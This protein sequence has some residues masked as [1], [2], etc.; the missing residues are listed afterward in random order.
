[1]KND[2]DKTFEDRLRI[3]LSAMESSLPPDGFANIHKELQVRKK[4]RW[5]IFWVFLSF[6]IF[7][8]GLLGWM[9]V[10]NRAT[11]ADQKALVLVPSGKNAAS[12]KQHEAGLLSK[13]EAVILPAEIEKEYQA[14]KEPKRSSKT[15]NKIQLARQTEAIRAPSLEHGLDLKQIESQIPKSSIIKKEDTNDRV[16]PFAKIPVRPIPLLSD[17]TV[18]LPSEV[19]FQTKSLRGLK[20]EWTVLP[21]INYY[22]IIPN[23]KDDAHFYAL[24]DQRTD[25]TLGTSVGLWRPVSSKITLGL[26]AYYFFTRTA[27]RLQHIEKES[28]NNAI[29]QLPDSHEPLYFADYSQ[30]FIDLSGDF[31]QLGLGSAIR[32]RL[33]SISDQPLEV[34]LAG[35]YFKLLNTND[36]SLFPNQELRLALSLGIKQ[37]LNSNLELAIHPS[38]AYGFTLH[39]ATEMLQI[40]RMIFGLGLSI[41]RQ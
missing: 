18:V 15:E 7:S 17:S 13:K 36:G 19:V 16:L 27:L 14:T 11:I 26:Q 29:I 33:F 41:K 8:G 30:K 9:Y 25:L 3:K 21:G 40:N 10:P 24:D 35:S 31:H 39:S 28:G 22:H 20:Y 32:Y 2:W 37:P 1:M 12:P 6:L 23:Q 5:L 4:R 38:F 34:Q